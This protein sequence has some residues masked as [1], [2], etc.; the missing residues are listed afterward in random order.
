MQQP[1]V[2]VNITTFN[3][4]KL[5]LNSIDSILRQSYENI[6]IVVVDDCSSDDTEIV[7]RQYTNKHD[8]IRYYRHLMNMGNAKARNTALEKCKGIFVAFMD[9]DDEWIDEEKLAKQVLI[10][11]NNRHNIGIICSS[12]RLDKGNG[13]FVDKVI[14]KPIDLK[15]K[16]LSGNGVIYSPTVLTSRQIMKQVGGFDPNMKRGVDS[17]FYRTCIVQYKYDVYF[18]DEITTKIREY[19]DD[20]MTL[21]LDEKE[22]VKAIIANLYLVKK[23]YRHYFFSPRAMLV[24]FRT[25]FFL[26]VNYI[27]AK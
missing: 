17:E 20:R 19:G 3:R 27:R 4:S 23:Y 15:E 25:I 1:L 26:L 14:H 6:E 22:I 8:N 13:I 16:I 5:L 21:A 9:D 2:S 7:I 18:M 12:V 11:N 10:L 24:R